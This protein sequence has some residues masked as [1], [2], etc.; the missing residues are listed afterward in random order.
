MYAVRWASREV[1]GEPDWTKW[2]HYA[3][4]HKDGDLTV[5]GLPP[6]IGGD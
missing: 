3:G 1:R 6:L 2:H 5:C 4:D